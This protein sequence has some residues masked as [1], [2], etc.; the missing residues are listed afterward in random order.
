MPA[1]KLSEREAR[2][3]AVSGI[4]HTHSVLPNYQLSCS[5]LAI[6]A[7]PTYPFPP[8]SRLPNLSLPPALHLFV[9]T[10]SGLYR[11]ETVRSPVR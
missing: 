11:A 1:L 6:D 8:T 3:E 4:Y 9:C 10:E 2:S 7:V 5:A